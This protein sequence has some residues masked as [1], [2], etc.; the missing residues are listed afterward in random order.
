MARIGASAEFRRARRLRAFLAF[1]VERKLAG[2]EGEITETVI[3][4][5]VFQRREN[6]NSGEDSIVRTEAR[7]LRQRLERYFADAGAAEPVIIEI[8]RGGYVPVFRVRPV[9]L[10]SVPAV[11]PDA[12]SVDAPAFLTRRRCIWLGA[13]AVCLGGAAS[14]RNRLHSPG[15]AGSARSSAAHPA[16]SVQLEASDSRLVAGFGRAK[17]RALTCVYSG[18][19]VG[20]WYTSSL[21]NRSFCARDV[22]HESRGAAVLGLDGH[23]ANMLRR[24]AASVAKSRDW[25]GYWV[26]TK[27]GFPSPSNYQSDSDFGYCLPANLDLLR[28]CHEQYLWTGNAEYLDPVCTSFYDHTVTDY[29]DAWD[30]DHDGVMEN[31]KERKRILASYHRQP[32]PFLTG[33][34][35]LAAQYA[36]YVAYAAIQA[37]KGVRGSLSHRLAEEFGSKAAALRARFNTEWWNP[38]RNCFY[39]AVLPGGGFDADYVADCNVYPLWFGIPDAGPKTEAALDAMER[40]RPPGDPTFS[41]YPEV[42]YRYGRNASAYRYLMEITDPAFPASDT[43]EPAF[44]AI[45]AVAMGLMGL[46]P[47]AT[48]RR[49]ETASRLNGETE[50]AKLSRVPV[51]GNEIAVE[52]RGLRQTTLANHSGPALQWKASFAANGTARI[53]VD[54]AAVPALERNGIVSAVVTVGPEQARTA[55][56]V[57]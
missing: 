54:G 30:L 7:S 33:A 42:L 39:S 51:M 48:I 50:W 24:F 57:A 45:G 32:R 12:A 15:G 55:R 38:A 17:E 53:L 19:P 4:C 26:I 13:A 44:A 10:E 6:Y 37:S 8:P 31:A 25:C 14:V 49:I 18:D 16:G 1:V 46:A 35:L 20:Q 36:G 9:Q 47:D 28:T 3:G 27:D 43:S 56:L 52:H 11:R 34:D 5:E 2:T 40:D 23:T 41:F 21:R 22:A 29:V